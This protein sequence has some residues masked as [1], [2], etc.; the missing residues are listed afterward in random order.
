MFLIELNENQYSLMPPNQC[1]WMYTLTK[2]T[3]T[4][5]NVKGTKDDVWAYSSQDYDQNYRL[6]NGNWQP[7]DTK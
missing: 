7:V 4:L 5:W 2:I 6:I 3:D 1:D